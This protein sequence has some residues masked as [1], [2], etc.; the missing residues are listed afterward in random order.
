MGDH[1]LDVQLVGDLFC[2]RKHRAVELDVPAAGA[3]L[4]LVAFPSQ[5]KALQLPQRV[6]AQATGHDWVVVEM[7]WKEPEVRRDIQLGAHLAFSEWAAIVSD[8]RDSVE[9]QHRRQWQLGVAFT[10]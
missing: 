8:C 7:A 5:E 3:A 9:H 4:A 10:E 2:G 1:T 6:Q